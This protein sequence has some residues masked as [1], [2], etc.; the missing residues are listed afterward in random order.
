LK[1]IWAG[2]AL[3]RLVEIQDFVARAN[4]TA[5]KRLTHR[6]VERGDRLSKFPEMGRTVPELPG[7]GIREIIEGRYRIVYRIQAK[8]VQVLTVFE[9]H[10]QFPTEDVED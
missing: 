6:I 5:A 10:R 8:V 9:G 1:V 4:P 3:M 2:Q 7:T